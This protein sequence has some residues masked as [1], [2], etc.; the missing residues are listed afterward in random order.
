M[1]VGSSDSFW[2]EPL[3][4]L[5]SLI[6]MLEGRPVKLGTEKMLS[7]G[8]ID[9]RVDVDADELVLLIG[10]PAVD[11]DTVAALR[12]NDVVGRKDVSGLVSRLS[13]SSP[14]LPRG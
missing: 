8:R 7:L 3:L 4:S 10:D 9:D 13:V 6:A 5:L 12:E 2:I 11:E 1:A 14:S